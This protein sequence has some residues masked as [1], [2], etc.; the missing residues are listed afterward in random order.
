MVE[1]LLA[2]ADVVM[3]NFRPGV[4]ERLG[5]SYERMQALKP[6]IIY[7]SATGFGA[8]GPMVARPGQDLL[9]QA[10][11]GLVAVT[12]QL[13]TR[14]TAV[15]H[16][17][18]D[19]HGA[20]ILAL[21]IVGAYVKKLKT[22]QGTRVEASLLNAGLD[23]QTEPL[24]IYLTRRL[25]ADDGRK[26][27]TR[28]ENLATWFHE[29]PY[30]IY[31]CADAWLALS[32]ND[33][34]KL[35]R[36]L[37][38]DGWRR[39]PAGSLRRARRLAEAVAAELAGQTSPS[40]GRGLRSRGDLVPAGARV[41]RPPGRPADPPQRGLPRGAGQARPRDPG[42][43]P[44]P[45]RRR[46][47]AATP[48]GARDR[49]RQPRGAG[50]ARLRRRARSRRCWP[51]ARSTAPAPM[52]SAEAEHERDFHVQVGDQVRFAKTVGESDVYLFAGIT[53]DLSSNHVN[54][55]V[56][57]RSSYGRR[58]AHGAL[59]IGFMSTT[60]TLMIE[61]SGGVGA[62]ETPVSLGYDRIRFL[63]PVFIGDTIT[64]TYRIAEV[65]PARR[66]SRSEIKVTNQDGTLVAVGQ[67]L[68]KWVA[69]PTPPRPA[70]RPSSRGDGSHACNCWAPERL[71]ELRTG[72]Q[73]ADG[74]LTH[75]LEAV[76]GRRIHRQKPGRT[77]G[78]KRTAERREPPKR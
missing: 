6:D 54:E 58:I 61:Q 16:A 34:A 5:L 31:R 2:S 28:N 7:A 3:E 72:G 37:G 63:A 48:S 35:A 77:P 29:A 9:I 53:G 21:G 41:R 59:L 44:E 10:Y 17:A 75:R 14:P 11:C 1:R 55:E 62:E 71:R 66:R 22:G 52:L 4:M 73:L 19:Q 32:I 50:R 15:G 12:G 60:S 76:P 18:V 68:L 64:V 40:S 26:L 8:S 49:R 45:L 20:A 67:H 65:D 27:F 23:L 47:A 69:N 33:T 36:A 42:Q 13:D 78:S 57:Q 43:P 39:S 24:T 51:R 30:G 74:G 70:R 56:M 46:G 25:Q 38:S